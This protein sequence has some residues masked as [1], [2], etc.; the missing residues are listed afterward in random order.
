MNGSAI[1]IPNDSAER[2]T[3]HSSSLVKRSPSKASGAEVVGGRDARCAA[4]ATEGT[5]LLVSG[6]N[7]A[8][9]VPSLPQR[10]P[11]QLMSSAARSPTRSRA[12]VSDHIRPISIV[13]RDVLRAFG[14]A[15]TRRAAALSSDR[16]DG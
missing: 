15:R 2:C 14:W 3:A 7:I 10:S 9:R 1:N 5:Y 13:R 8:L 11:K 6:A 16:T 12:S 4:L